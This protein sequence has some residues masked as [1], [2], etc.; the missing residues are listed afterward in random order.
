MGPGLFLGFFL[1]AIIIS[2]FLSCL[3]PFTSLSSSVEWVAIR[4]N[5]NHACQMPGTVCPLPEKP[6]FTACYCIAPFQGGT[7]VLE[8]DTPICH[9]PSPQAEQRL[10]KLMGKYPAAQKTRGWWPWGRRLGGPR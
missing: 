9:P 3:C 2:G 10:R 5:W 7:G 1:L 4:L 8:E 6:S